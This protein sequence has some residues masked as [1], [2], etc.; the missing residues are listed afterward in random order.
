MA[1][2]TLFGVNVT[3]IRYN[4]G[5]PGGFVDNGVPIVKFSDGENGTEVTIHVDHPRI[6]PGAQWDSDRRKAVQQLRKLT[7]AFRQAADRVEEL[8][9]EAKRAE[10]DED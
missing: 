10:Q 3:D 6:N 5:N 9:D 8:A 4:G 7:H 2:L 1:M